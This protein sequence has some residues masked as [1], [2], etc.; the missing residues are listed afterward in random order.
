MILGDQKTSKG[1]S[2]KVSRT[3]PPPLEYPAAGGTRQFVNQP[4]YSSYP[5]CELF[6]DHKLG[7]LVTIMLLSELLV[8]LGTVSVAFATTASAASSGFAPHRGCP[9]LPKNIALT[10]QRRCESFVLSTIS[11]ARPSTVFVF[12]TSARRWSP[13]TVSRTRVRMSLKASSSGQMQQAKA[14]GEVRSP[15]LPGDNEGFTAKNPLI[16]SSV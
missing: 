10:K 14:W 12:I 8:A 11:A 7:P 6:C 3:D 1:V 9:P 13:L 2:T 4:C 15:H 5:F 16:C